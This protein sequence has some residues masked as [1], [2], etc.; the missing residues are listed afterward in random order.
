M[1][2]GLIILVPKISF[3]GTRFFPKTLLKSFP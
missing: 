2:N 3:R 1:E